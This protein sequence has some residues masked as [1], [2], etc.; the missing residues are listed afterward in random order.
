MTVNSGGTA[1]ANFAIDQA[2][3]GRIVTTSAGVV[4]LNVNSANNLDLHAAGANLTAA[5]LGA[6]RAFTYSGT[7]TPNGATYRLGGGTGTL[8]VSSALSGAN[9]LDVGL[10][11]TASGTVASTNA[12]NN[13]SGGTSV[14]GGTLSVATDNVLGTGNLTLGGG[15]LL[16]GSGFTTSKTVTL[17]ALNGGT[18]GVQ[19]NGSESAMLSGPI[20]GSWRLPATA[21]SSARPAPAR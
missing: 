17:A 7:L 12:G 21:P 4:A 2:F 15:T 1:A 9:S 6:T 13:Y 8:T 3:L 10:G 20:S 11:G 18:T 14:N 19:V 5:R 16:V